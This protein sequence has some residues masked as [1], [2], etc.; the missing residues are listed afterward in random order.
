MYM[1]VHSFQHAGE[2]TWFVSSQMRYKYLHK[3]EEQ[4]CSHI[5]NEIPGLDC[6]YKIIKHHAVVNSIINHYQLSLRH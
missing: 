1:L 4:S 2:R 3:K 5:P 6:S